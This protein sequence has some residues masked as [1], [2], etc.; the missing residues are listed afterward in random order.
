MEHDNTFAA[1]MGRGGKKVRESLAVKPLVE[2]YGAQRVLIEHHRGICQYGREEICV[3]VDRG[4][5]LVQGE[6]L[7]LARIAREQ[8]VICGKIDAVRFSGRREP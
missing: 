3:N 8:L 1:R 6:G 2:I 4:C 5:I 7:H